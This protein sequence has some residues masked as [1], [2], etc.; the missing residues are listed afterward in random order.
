M[1]HQ[2]AL[3]SLSASLQDLQTGRMD[4]PAFNTMW[5]SQHSLLAALPPRY[6]EVMEDLLGR[7]EAGRLFSE[8]SCSFSQE[9]LQANLRVW[10]AK[11]QEM[12]EAKN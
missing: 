3:E 4:L 12:L 2:L 9:D 6:A 8:E 7:M 11:A 5:R 1:S 10:L